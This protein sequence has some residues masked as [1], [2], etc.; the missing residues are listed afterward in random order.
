MRFRVEALL[1]TGA[2]LFAISLQ[3][4]MYGGGYEGD[5]EGGV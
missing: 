2:L 4:H 1:L 5:G 3:V